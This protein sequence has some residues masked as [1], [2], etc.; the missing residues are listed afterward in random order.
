MCVC[1][2]VCV[3]MCVYLR[4]TIS[5]FL[6]LTLS[7]SLSHTHTQPAR[8]EAS[9]Y[10]MMRRVKEEEAASLQKETQF[11]L[12]KSELTRIYTLEREELQKQYDEVRGL[13]TYIYTH[14]H[15]HT[16]VL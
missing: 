8:F 2:S 10:K 7:L 5:F 14:I 16:H 11:R 3:C 4:I 12:E 9:M 15:T 1:V 13:D 6:F